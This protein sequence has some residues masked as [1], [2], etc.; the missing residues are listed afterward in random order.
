MVV[1]LHPPPPPSEDVEQE[2]AR[3]L[4]PKTRVEHFLAKIAGRN[5][6]G[7]VEPKTRLEHFLADIA[8]SCGSGDTRVELIPT[9]VYEGV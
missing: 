4:E 1:V 8:E 7:D 2:T 5:D 6:V 9:D 3:H